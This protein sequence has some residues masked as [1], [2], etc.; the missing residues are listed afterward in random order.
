MPVLAMLAPGL[1]VALLAVVLAATLRRWF[2]PIPGRCW[3][4]W[5]A[6][7]AV[8]FGAVLFA[9]RVLLPL[10]Y[11]TE[12][13]P[14]RL[15][16]EGAG[17][18][19][20]NLLQSDLILQITPWLAR[21]RALFA[22]GE[23]PMWN[24][25]VG[26]G[27]PLLGN[28]QSQALQPLVWLVLPFPVPAEVGMLAALRVLLPLAFMYLLL[29]RRGLGETAAL[30]ASLAFG[31]SGF[32]QLSLGWPLAGSAT[33][34]PLLLYGL[35]LVAQRG[36]RRD[37]A[38]LAAA[39]AAALLVGHPETGLH[40]ALLGALFSL[41]L[42]RACPAGARRRV[43]RDWLAA[44]AVGGA[45]A[46]PVLLPAAAFIPQTVRVAILRWRHA[47]IE[48][49]DPL[50]G[51]RTPAERAASAR[52]LVARLVPNAAPN[53]YGNNR[54]GSYWG[55]RN[56]NE[57]AAGF[58]GTAA[59]L[60][61][62]VA[63]APAPRRAARRR[64]GGAGGTAAA[65]AGAT[66]GPGTELEAGE[67]RPGA[68]GETGAPGGWRFPEERIV[69]AV[70]LACLVVLA[71]PPG[72]IQLLEALPVV[73]QSLSFH[74]R[75]SLLLDFCIAYAAGCTWERWRRGRLPRLPVVAAA[76]ALALL[77]VWAYQAHPN[78][79]D[80][81]ALAGL[82][83]GTLALQLAVLAAAAA[84][85]LVRRRRVR[86]GGEGSG[87]MGAA[88]GAA[89]GSGETVRGWQVWAGAA[90]VAGEL[91]AIHAPANPPVLSALYYPR[92]RPIAF[93]AER[94]DPW[95]RMAGVGP[96]LRANI[97]SIYGLADPRS[98]NPIK[99]AAYVEAIGRIDA[100]PWRAT[101]GFVSVEDPLYGLLGVRWVMV[102]SKFRLPWPLRPAFRNAEAWVY[103]RP[104]A[105]AR[106][107]LPAA[108]AR[109]GQ[110][111]WSP[112]TAG[113]A[114]FSAATA[115]RGGPPSWAA[116]HPG[117]SSLDLIALRPAEIRA[118]ARLAEPRLVAS[119]IY[120]DGGWKL[121]AGGRPHPTSLAN[122]PFVAA[123]LAAGET[124]LD[125]LYR[126]AELVAGLLAAALALAAAAALWVPPP[127]HRRGAAGE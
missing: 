30:W 46:A 71:R 48:R 18:P 124:T 121:L 94:L 50:A 117:A 7:L 54:F 89:E 57:D 25:L 32:L 4:A 73:R 105:L 116:A 34:L 86:Q 81:G 56:I 78:P 6:A 107:F 3:L 55:N 11:L 88:T 38:L 9:G 127:S 113:I 102:E 70:A 43:L 51:W 98:S 58:A 95:H 100:F 20:G 21:V 75:V 108:S 49:A 101:D 111:V 8:L 120:Q 92:M 29:R 103:E 24:H 31:L 77:L 62:L 12:V 90:L 68:D 28:P 84:G 23:W 83:R 52:A 74:S 110:A 10:G 14:Y 41:S 42:L 72:L 16:W 15:M 114:D 80:P 126:P 65:E 59:L 85:L 60:A 79:R 5:A 123:W 35:V 27:E 125:L 87:G 96:A 45:L 118:R 64:A 47:E 53:A 1:Y 97:P 44:G 67:A 37:A 66:A 106:L 91:L 93:I 19:P 69:L 26:A 63:C 33:F 112:C 109:C 36:A 2:D 76:A 22:A 115:V 40:V 122:G 17:P 119:S 61:C 99:P 104:G 39:V 82:R 13:P